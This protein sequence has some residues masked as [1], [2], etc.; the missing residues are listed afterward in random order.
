[1]LAT[2]YKIRSWTDFLCDFRFG[3]ELTCVG[4]RRFGKFARLSSHAAYR[5][6]IYTKLFS[7]LWNGAYGFSIERSVYQPQ[8]NH[9]RHFVLLEMAYFQKAKRLDG[10]IRDHSQSIPWTFF[11][12]KSFRSDFF[13][14]HYLLL[15]GQIE[16]SLKTVFSSLNCCS[17]FQL[18][19]C[20][21][22]QRFPLF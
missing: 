22:A 19:V 3:E 11:H 15:Q 7:A 21:L 2:Q 9:I 8:T 17:L 1:M 6:T 16:K 14:S 18:N 13:S 5:L 20:F 12:P 10:K 4:K